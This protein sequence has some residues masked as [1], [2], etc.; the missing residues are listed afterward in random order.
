MLTVSPGLKREIE[1]F[2]AQRGSRPD[3]EGRYPL[4]REPAARS[5]DLADG[6]RLLPRVQSAILS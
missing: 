5:C 1:R 3:S 4:L 2:R 6:R